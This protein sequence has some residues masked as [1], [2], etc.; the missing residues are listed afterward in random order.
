MFRAVESIEAVG[1][2]PTAQDRSV[3]QF[4]E[5][6]M[7]IAAFILLL[8]TG[9]AT[10][11]PIRIDFS[12]TIERVNNT[13]IVELGDRFTGFAVI[14]PENPNASSYEVSLEGI[15]IRA[16]GAFFTNN[17]SS[18]QSAIL[19]IGRADAPYIGRF[20]PEEFL[21]WFFAAPGVFQ[22]G[23]PYFDSLDQITGGDFNARWRDNPGYDMFTFGGSIDSVQV[24]EPSSLLLFVTALLGGTAVVRRKRA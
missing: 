20:D 3:N 16:G 18:G 14:N 7:R 1:R 24:P 10:A 19:R 8:W 21:L 22:N 11:T 6:R 12:G 13:N 9:M 5:K 23:V 2:T 4:R 17:H 15:L